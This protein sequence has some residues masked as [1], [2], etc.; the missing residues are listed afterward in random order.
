[1]KAAI[2]RR[3]DHG[4][5]LL[6]IDGL[7]EINDP[8]VR[9]SFC[10]QLEQIHLARP[11]TPIIATSRIVGY[12]EMGYRIGRGF[13]HLTVAELDRVGQGRLHPALV[14]GHRAPGPPADRHRAACRGHP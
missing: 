3:L 9:A 13:E 1:V 8:G 2:S 7:D 4:T 5:A 12:R 6:L 11:D 10:R 14:R